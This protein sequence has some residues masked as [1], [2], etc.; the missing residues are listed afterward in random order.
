MSLSLYDRRSALVVAI[1][2]RRPRV[3]VETPQPPNLGKER[4]YSSRT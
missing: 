2:P 3:T 4:A 1:E